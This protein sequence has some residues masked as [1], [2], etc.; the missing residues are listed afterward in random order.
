MVYGFNLIYS[1]NFLAQIERDNFDILRVQLGMNPF[2]FN[3][4]LKSG[5]E[6]VCP[7]A[8][9]VFS[10][11]GFNQM[12]QT[13]HRFYMNHL[14]RSPWKNWKRPVLI[15]N[16]EATYFDFTEEKLLEIVKV[17]K[18][19]GVD[20]FVLDDGWFGNRNSDSGSLGNWKENLDKFPSG[21]KAFSEKVHQEGLLFGL[22]F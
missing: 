14:I 19:L 9:M 20:L 17:S 3:W 6:F 4:L 5:Q 16:W 22:W 2:Q 8:V 13:F 15:N 10:N 18:D 11:Q 7:E 12:S 21:L 1:G